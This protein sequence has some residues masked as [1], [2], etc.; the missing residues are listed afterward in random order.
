MEKGGE[1]YLVTTLVL[2]VDR[3]EVLKYNLINLNKSGREIIKGI[4]FYKQ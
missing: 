2:F 4:E 3:K 1:R